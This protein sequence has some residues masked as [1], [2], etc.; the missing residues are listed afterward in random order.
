M[1]IQKIRD[2]FPILKNEIIYFDNA[3]T[4]LT[5]KQVVSAEVEYYEKFNAN[6]HRGV[7][8]L[9][10]V[11]SQKYESVY[12]KVAKFIN[13]KPDEIAFTKNTTEGINLIARGLNFKKGELKHESN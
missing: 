10:Q 1:D 9:S 12:G 11:A 4:S 8:R 6:I 7:H 2:D 5:P 3:A 13:S